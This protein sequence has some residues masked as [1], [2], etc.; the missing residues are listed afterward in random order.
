MDT[1]KGE[2]DEAGQEEGEEEEVTIFCVPAIL[3]TMGNLS[4]TVGFGLKPN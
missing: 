2:S 4:V 3:E 1:G